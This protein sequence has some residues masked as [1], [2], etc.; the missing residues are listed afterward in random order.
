MQF[1]Y[2]TSDW[3]RYS[4]SRSHRLVFGVVHVSLAHFCYLSTGATPSY[5]IGFPKSRK[6]RIK[7][8]I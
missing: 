2:E 3:Y 6:N 4:Q 8:P 5:E 1:F 7:N